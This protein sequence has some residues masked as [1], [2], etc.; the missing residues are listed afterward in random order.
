MTTTPNRHTWKFNRIGGLDQVRFG[1]G[2]DLLHLDQLDPKLWVALSCPTKGLEFDQRTLDYID[3]DKDGHIRV[4]EIISAVQWAAAQLKDPGELLRPADALPLNSINSTTDQG[5]ALLAS[6]RQ[7]LKNLGKADAPAIALAD[8][9]DGPRIFRDSRFNGDGIVTPTTAQDPELQKIIEEIIQVSGSAIDRTG[10]PGI[11]QARVDNFFTA[12]TDY[13]DWRNAEENCLAPA[14][15]AKCPG[16]L[17]AKAF[18]AYREVKP[19]I[20]DYFTRC[21]LAAFDA[22][23]AGEL[24]PP[25][26]SFKVLGA[27]NLADQ[28][29]LDGPIGNLPAQTI[30]PDKPLDLAQP[31]NPAWAEAFE[32]FRRDAAEPL[33][34]ASAAQIDATEWNRI[35]RVFAGYEAWYAAKKGALVESLGI[36]RIRAI[37]NG[38]HRNRINDLI[39][40]DLKLAAEANAIDA[41]DKLVRFYCHLFRLLKNFTNFE[42]FYSTRQTAIFQLGTMYLD[43]RSFRLCIRVDDPGAHAALASTS[44]A[45]L[46]YCACT[47]KANSAEKMNL[48]VAVTQGDTDYISVGR[49]GVFYDFKGQDWDATVVKVIDNPISVKQAFWSPYKRFAKLVEE[50]IQKFASSKDKEIIDS[51]AHTAHETVGA[52]AAAGKPPA[53]PPFDIARFAGIF[54]AIG[55]A[56]GAIGGAIGA[57]LSAFF[58]IEWWQMPLAIVGMLL[59]ISGP[60]IVMAWFNLRKRNLGPLLEANGWA[61]NGRVRINIPLGNSMTRLSKLPAGSALSR[62]DPFEDK[63]AKR[64][65]ILTSSFFVVVILA[66]LYFFVFKPKFIDGPREAAHRAWLKQYQDSMPP[67]RRAVLPQATDPATPAP[68]A[69]P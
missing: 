1:S 3:T 42:D 24:N 23:A 4:P 38:N 57:M 29:Q 41:V 6:A 39:A 52:G 12:L 10:K 43:Q 47:R 36:D 19:K 7:I 51:A 13:R 32:R 48:A 33:L 69:K 20:A 28:L 9:A 44:R 21:R 46:M 40:E 67:A 37:L 53:K 15:R 68:V 25:A 65:S 63:E 8:T 50:Q 16:D 17:P 49:N 56:I 27:R 30:G 45:H 5:K 22:K 2:E 11:D 58:S 66:L 18:A 60:S 31:L 26:D 54:A 34:G 59:V 55:L 14:D 61:I 35:V 64:R 62:K